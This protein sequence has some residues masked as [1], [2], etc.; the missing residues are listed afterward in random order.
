ML[1]KEQKFQDVDL[2]LILVALHKAQCSGMY[3]EVLIKF[4]HEGGCLEVKTQYSEKIK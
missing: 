1:P 3:A 2:P 4:S